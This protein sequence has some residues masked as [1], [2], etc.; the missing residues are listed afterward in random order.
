[1]THTQHRLAKTAAALLCALIVAPS[2]AAT[3]N[4]SNKDTFSTPTWSESGLLMTAESSPGVA[5]SLYFLNYNG[6]GVVGGSSS[7]L[8]D[9]SERVFFTA[10][11]GSS[12]TGI[13]LH[14]TMLTN[15]DGDGVLGEALVEGFL[16]MT[17]L[18]TRSIGGSFDVN[19]SSLFTGLTLTRFSVRPNPDSL[20]LYSLDFTV[21]PL[22]LHWAN[23]QGGQWDTAANWDMG[24]VPL[25]LTPV[26]IDPAGGLTVSGP[27]RNTTVASLVLGARSS[28]VAVLKLDPAADLWVTGVAS[29][30]SRG[31]IELGNT[32]VLRA[33][34]LDNAGVLRGSGQVDARI[35]NLAGGRVS[36][37]AG[38][39]IEFSGAGASQNAGMIEVLG[40]EVGFTDSVVNVAGT[41]LIAGRDAVLRFDGGL[42]NQGSVALSSG[43]SDVF[44]KIDNT[45]NIALGARTTA[46]FYD[47]L[48]QNGSFIVP[49]S[50]AATLLGAFSGSGGFTGG[51]E[52]VVLG[53][54]RPGNSPAVVVY[55]G[56][57]TLGPIAH[58]AIDIEGLLPGQYDLLQ[59]TGT[60]TLDGSLGISVGGGFSLGLGQSFAFLTAAGGVS[61]QY[62][63]LAQG[64]VVGSFGGLPLYIGYDANSVMLYTD[65]VPEPRA[66][67]L[68]LA[69]LALVIGVTGRHRGHE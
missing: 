5:G 21:S 38:Q 32:S 35:D 54:L 14:Q 22:T 61:G 23:S 63:G 18:G 25:A 28:G 41:G 6:L 11:G 16:G 39:R 19:I 17:S 30:Q 66:Y 44:G 15:S 50:S 57:L 7:T 52:V 31:A 53:D 59:V 8:I 69:G 62:A 60:A 9:G 24:F 3:I 45:G 46:T 43:N 55:D 4:F 48:A 36:V 26:V 10:E 68:M 58:T 29:V 51:G 1:M 65:P 67:L 47:D 56:D 42:T 13:A 40:G 37:G 33:G 27:T 20:R 64:G 12:L 34:Q 49:S 2:D